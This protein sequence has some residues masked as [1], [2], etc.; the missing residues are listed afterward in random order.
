M[1]GRNFVQNNRAPNQG[2]K[3]L[4]S[5]NTNYPHNDSVTTQLIRNYISHGYHQKAVTTLQPIKNIH[6]NK[7]HKFWLAN[8]E[9]NNTQIHH[10]FKEN[11][12]NIYTQDIIHE[13]SFEYILQFPAIL[14]TAYHSL[15]Y[16]LASKLGNK[17]KNV[18]I[19]A[20]NKNIPTELL[21]N[22]IKT[23][24]LVIGMNNS[25]LYDFIPYLNKQH[26]MIFFQSAKDTGNHHGLP[27]KSK[28]IALQKTIFSNNNF[29]MFDEYFPTFFIENNINL[30]RHNYAQIHEE[31]NLFFTYPKSSP[32]IYSPF[33]FPSS[34]Y[35]I[36]LYFYYSYLYL[37]DH[38]KP[39]FTLNLVGF[40]NTQGGSFSK[41]H[42][43]NYERQ[44]VEKAKEQ[45]IISLI[46]TA[47]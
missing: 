19:L 26:L 15:P 16:G 29:I 38:N 37:K 46:S 1:N 10:Y 3:I 12:P 6:H 32:D 18:Y 2:F 24:D 13:L 4:E 41:A 21:M 23:N 28:Y 42:N 34:G 40:E 14:A 22:H 17:I 30:H 43:W 45:G 35:M 7:H 9:S 25:V 8:Q 20:N 36:F 5:L 27:I 44:Q 47:I 11:H 39:T 33:S 31:S